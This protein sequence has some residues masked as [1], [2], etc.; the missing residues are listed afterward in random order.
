MP[1]DK[2]CLVSPYQFNLTIVG[3]NQIPTYSY[4]T[5]STSFQ[6]VIFDNILLH[7]LLTLLNVPPKMRESNL[8]ATFK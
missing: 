5:V 7:I 1:L 2:N 3:R 6:N 4:Q 8:D